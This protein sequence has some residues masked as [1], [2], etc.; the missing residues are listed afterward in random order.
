MPGPEVVSDEGLAHAARVAA[1][2]DDGLQSLMKD[3]TS[4]AAVAVDGGLQSLA[5]ALLCI[6]CR[7]C[8]SSKAP[9]GRRRGAPPPPRGPPL[10][11]LAPRRGGKGDRVFW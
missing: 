3:S 1:A 7:R 6:L 9:W 8:S 10:G 2:V 11:G 5:V 4:S